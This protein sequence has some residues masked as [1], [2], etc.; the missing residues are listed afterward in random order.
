MD[1]KYQVM[2][3]ECFSFRSE[4]KYVSSDVHAVDH[5]SIKITMLHSLFFSAI[6]IDKISQNSGLIVR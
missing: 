6:F 2:D 5:R 1:K 3:W 4:R